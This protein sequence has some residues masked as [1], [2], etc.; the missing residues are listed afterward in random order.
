MNPFD[1]IIKKFNPSYKTA[2]EKFDQSEF[3]QKFNTSSIGIGIN[4]VAGLPKATVD[5]GKDILRGIA[6]TGVGFGGDV[7]NAFVAPEKRRFTA[8]VPDLLK[9][10]LGPEPIKTIAQKVTEAEQ[11]IKQSPT[12]ER[13]GVNKKLALPL[14]FGGTIGLSAL[15][16]TPLGSLE[17]NAVK[18]LLRETTI[19]GAAKILRSLKVPEAQIAKHAPI[20][21]AAKTEKEVVSALGAVKKE[22]EAAKVAGAKITDELK[23]SVAKEISQIDTRPLTVNG[24]PYLEGDPRIPTRLDELKKVIETRDLSTNETNE[25]I[26]LL[27][28]SGIDVLKEKPKTLAEIRAGKQP[29]NRGFAKNPLAN[30]AGRES[31]PPK[32]PLKAA[33]EVPRPVVESGA[34]LDRSIA[35]R[36]GITGNPMETLRNAEKRTGVK[37]T[38]YHGTRDGAPPISDPNFRIRDTKSSPHNSPGLSLTGDQSVAKIYGKNVRELQIDPKAKIIKLEE[39]MRKSGFDDPGLSLNN[40]EDNT[41]KW[42]SE[43]GYDGI[44][45][46]GAKSDFYRSQD[47]IRIFNRNVVKEKPVRYSAEGIPLALTSKQEAI[48]RDSA[49]ARTTPELPGLLKTPSVKVP[50][51][52][53]STGELRS[54]ERQAELAAT[55]EIRDPKLRKAASLPKIIERSPTPVKAKVNALDYMRTPENVLKKIGLSKQA[56]TIRTAYDGYVKELPQNIDKISGWAKQLPKESSGR[57]F[58]YLDGQ[59][60]DLSAEEVKVAGE[61]K[62]WLKEW[63]DRLDLPEDKRIADYITHI[64]DDQLLKKEFDEDLA[65][66]I[67]EK[68]PG[69]VY[70]PFL[71]KR[72]G[73]KGYKEDVWAALDAY[74]KRATRKVHMDPALESLQNAAGHLE[75]SQWNYVKRFADRINLRPTE[76]DNLIDNGIK[77]II[78]YRAGQRPV[79]AITKS[80][81]RATYRGMLGLN[82]GSALRNLSQGINTYAKLGEKY[83]AL[84]YS[85]LFSKAN[86]L[87]LE[88]SGVLSSSFVQ[89][90]AMSSAKRAMEKFDKVLFYMFET[91]EK[92]NRGA[93]YFGAKA[94]GIASGMSEEKAVEY[95]KR[96]VRE[97]QFQFGSIDTP[98]GMSSDI[99]KTLAQ[100]QTF[101]TK[102]IEFLVGMAKNKEYAGLIRYALSGIAFVYT[103]GQAFGMKPQ[104]LVPLY[105]LGVPPSLKLPYEAASAAVGA[106][107]DYG[108]PRSAT[109][110]MKDVIGTLP[111]YIP[112]GIQAKKTIQGYQAIKEGGSYDA[113]GRLQFPQG[114]STAKKAQSLIF[115]KYSST[116]AK[117][118]FNRG[119]ITKE[120]KAKIQPVFD[121][122]QRLLSTG[123]TEG[124]KELVNQLSQADYLTYK[125]IK[126]A[127]QAQKTVEGK[128]AILPVFNEAQKLLNEGDAEG[129]KQLVNGLSDEEYKYYKLVKADQT[130]VE[131]AA[132]GDKPTFDADEVQSSQSVVSTVLTYAKA[133]GVDPV[134]AFN[135][136]FTGQRIRY[137]TNG[138]VVVER[139]PLSESQAIKREGGSTGAEVKLDHTIPLQLGGSNDK[140]N[141]RLVPT[142]LWDTYTPIENEL[143]KALRAGKITK[144]QAQQLI[145][146]FKSGLLTTD[147]VRNAII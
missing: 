145:R 141:L 140:D 40:A 51:R 58:R 6:R 21:A 42:A 24:K 73:S 139:L 105:R 132:S 135:R 8:E 143:G 16:L 41:V 99:A 30:M 91:A 116:E 4:T 129:A 63:A 130:K 79:A 102:Q 112:G 104:D 14:A 38:F 46:R 36:K 118:Y 28:Q 15:D 93:A 22:I 83:T 128:K 108:Q 44:D 52:S 70:N 80:L 111:G 43:N 53:V 32:L 84:G 124:A 25:A 68:V 94:K 77:S 54:I 18:P 120:E 47:E 147:E 26:G 113:T 122:A 39:A 98:V 71:L 100:F 117:A 57:I 2:R 123:D 33:E 106:P 3:G 127:T 12:A 27:K 66:I 9:P 146:D 78:G 37:D 125:K 19:E 45:L 60:V 134:T 136:I 107:D 144:K 7:R 75:E 61:I 35:Q 96:I 29:L 126:S 119:E 10:I 55:R 95:A 81:R 23:S 114:Q 56:D 103:V 34:S 142:A 133:I 1:Y 62:T 50:E 82:V 131:K 59:A 90:R 76:I 86:R 109:E 5:V 20:F 48:A 87:E 115:G 89:D 97:T 92:I 13:L 69:S 74:V 138:T 121:E 101:T 65:K 72:L 11:T 137:V 85:K 17:K 88:S 110:K 49:A 64:F 67:A 31:V